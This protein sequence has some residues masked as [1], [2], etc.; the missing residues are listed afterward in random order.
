[1]RRD[2]I[3]VGPFHCVARTNCNDR[4]AEAHH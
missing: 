2:R 1:V 4:I 3:F